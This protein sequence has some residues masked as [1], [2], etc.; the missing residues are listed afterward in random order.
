M[1]GLTFAERMGYKTYEEYM[2]QQDLRCLYCGD[3]FI[4][5]SLDK[6]TKYCCWGCCKNQLYINEVNRKKKIRN[7]NDKCVVCGKTIEQSALGK[8]RKYCSNKCKK[9]VYNEK[10]RNEKC[11]I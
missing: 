4:Y 11:Q 9:V 10:K 6:R 5:S 7:S 8:L 2:Q 3:K 1:E